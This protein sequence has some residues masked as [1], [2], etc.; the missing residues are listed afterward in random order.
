MD[1]ID[2]ID[3]YIPYTS[4][5]KQLKKIHGIRCIL[6]NKNWKLQGQSRIVEP[7]SLYSNKEGC[8]YVLKKDG[9]DVEDKQQQNKGRD[10]GNVFYLL[11]ESYH[12]NIFHDLFSVIMPPFIYF[13]CHPNS[14]RNTAYKSYFHRFFN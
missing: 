9:Q 6:K 8:V 12:H 11:N 14:D 7:S 2:N 4:A 13:N 1:T 5:L 3:K 10:E